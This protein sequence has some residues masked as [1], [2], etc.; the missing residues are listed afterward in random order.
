MIDAVSG[1]FGKGQDSAQ[2]SKVEDDQGSH[3]EASDDAKQQVQGGGPS[4]GQLGFDEDGVITGAVSGADPTSS[5]FWVR[6]DGPNGGDVAGASSRE[7]LRNFFA[8]NPEYTP[9]SDVIRPATVETLSVSPAP[10]TRSG[11]MR[12][13]RPIGASEPASKKP[14][15]AW[16]EKHG[17]S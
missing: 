12:G 16:S 5:A 10:D 6:V 15:A 1:L 13:L 4:R 8:A 3:A 7:T 9:A 11:F 2:T 17:I 14:P